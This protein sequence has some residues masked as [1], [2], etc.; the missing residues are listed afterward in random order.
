MSINTKKK[1]E[2]DT[3]IELEQE[4]K[5]FDFSHYP[6][7]AKDSGVLRIFYNNVNGLEIKNTINAQIINSKRKNT[8]YL[9]Q[10]KLIQK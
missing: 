8:Q 10:K 9:N 3:D 1:T 2:I 6:L 7:P 5:I 4:L